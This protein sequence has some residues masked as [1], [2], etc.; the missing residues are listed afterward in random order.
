M[1]I[2]GAGPRLYA[3]GFFLNTVWFQCMG[4]NTRY[5]RRWM[6]SLAMVLIACQMVLAA[7]AAPALTGVFTVRQPDGTQ[8]SIEQF[9]DEHLHWTATTDGV[10]VINRNGAYYVAAI[11]SDGDLSSTDVLAHAEE[12]RDGRERQLIALQLSRLSLFH[13]RQNC[14]GTRFPNIHSDGKYFPHQGSP[15]VLTILV[16]FQD[17]A[18]TVNDPAGAF[19]QYL[20]GETQ[21][22]LGNKNHYNLASVRQ[23]FDIC[24]RGQFT[25]Q[26]DI[27]GP[28]T[29]PHEMAY[30]GGNS[31]TGKDDK[32]FTFCSESIQKADEEGLVND[33]TVYDNDGDGTVEMVC[34]IYAGYGQNQGGGVETLWAQAKRLDMEAAGG[35]KI[36][37]FNCSPEH[38]YPNNK[39]DGEGIAVKDYING[40][41]VFT[42]EM[43]HCMGLPDLYQTSGDKTNNQ[44]MESWDIMDYGLYNRNG[45][46]PAPYTA[47][48]QEVMGWIDIEPITASQHISDLTPLEEGGK[49]FKWVNPASENGNEY[50][51]MESIMERGLSTYAYGSGLLVYHVAYPRRAIN[52]GDDPNNTIGRPSVAVVPASGTLINVSISGSGKQYTKAEWK[53]SMA[54]AV[55]PGINEVNSLT[56]EL[57]LPN[58]LFYDGDD[59]SLPVE[60]ELHDITLS[61]NGVSFDIKTPEPDGIR[62]ARPS[63]AESRHEW[64]DLLGHKLGSSPAN[65]NRLYIDR[66]TGRKYLTKE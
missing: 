7:F 44:G 22:D 50:I 51:V 18:F 4:M 1:F 34:I 28:V 54:G 48:E 2:G 38:Y 33:W 31:N 36:S 27:V 26:F 20:N 40:T 37:F 13:Q 35:T 25:P 39:I 62:P 6:Y 58:Y 61:D 41:G 29:L 3:L 53:S 11:D 66:V 52:L 49:A 8:L 17:S 59:A 55:F 24:S 12:M 60:L 32:F 5:N 16:A 57:E 45:Y 47:W 14:A 42:H 43:S 65:G 23:Y 63:L 56:P 46:A 9:G 19:D 30:Y 64:Y 21:K 15:R 10:F